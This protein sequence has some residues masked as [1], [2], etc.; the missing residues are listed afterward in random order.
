[1]SRCRAQ[2]PARKVASAA[3]ASARR[4]WARMCDG[5]AARASPSARPRCW[6][7][8][9]RPC[10]YCA[11]A[12]GRWPRVGLR[13]CVFRF[14]ATRFKHANTVFG[15][16][17]GI[18]SPRGSLQFGFQLCLSTDVQGDV[19]PF[20]PDGIYHVAYPAVQPLPKLPL[21]TRPRPEMRT[22]STSEIRVFDYDVYCTCYVFSART[23]RSTI[24]RHRPPHP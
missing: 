14:P 13:E 4:S 17:P 15:A 2:R 8:A 11:V 18:R 23:S 24:L 5:G 7:W 1:M 3:R 21:P 16:Q 10:S 12:G 19:C 9:A 6:A 22:S 20:S